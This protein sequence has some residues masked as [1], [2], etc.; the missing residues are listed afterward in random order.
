MLGCMCSITTANAQYTPLCPVKAEI[1]LQPGQRANREWWMDKE[2]RIFLKKYAE[3]NPDGEIVTSPFHASESNNGN[4][5]V[6]I[7]DLPNTIWRDNA[8]ADGWELVQYDF[9]KPDKRVAHAYLVLYNRFSAIL[10]IFL[11]VG[12]EEASLF[13]KATVGLTPM[14]L[15]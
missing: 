5:N 1:P 8:P 3:Q 2:F 11:L 12:E 7:L 6:N 4:Q 9:G 14:L 13:S 15:S 10:R